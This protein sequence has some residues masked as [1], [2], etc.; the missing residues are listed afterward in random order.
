MKENIARAATG[1]DVEDC[2]DLEATHHVHTGQTEDHKEAAKAF[3]ESASL[4]SRGISILNLPSMGRVENHRQ[5]KSRNMVVTRWFSGGE[6]QRKH[7]IRLIAGIVIGIVA[8]LAVVAG[9]SLLLRAVAPDVSAALAAH[10]TTLALAERLG[11]SVL[12][13][14]AAG[15]VAALI[16]R[17]RQASL[18]AGL[19]L[20]AGWGTFHVL[21]I[22]SQ[23]PLWYHLTFFVSLP[24]AQRP[25]RPA[26][27]G[28]I[29]VPSR[30]RDRPP[31]IRPNRAAPRTGLGS[32][33]AIIASGRGQP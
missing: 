1:A 13:S 10:A 8:W 26:R 2:M 31:P 20:L 30:R 3:V 24:L 14:L 5:R 22:W 9:V 18:I 19:L 16:A 28:K 12:G 7:M 4:C 32:R 23:F 17:D 33:L 27:Q 15:A 29:V 21:V 11:I 6:V 25:R